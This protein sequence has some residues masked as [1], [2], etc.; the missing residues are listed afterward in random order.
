MTAAQLR[1][2]GIF[3][4]E[5][6]PDA[7]QQLQVALMRCF[8][9]RFDECPTQCASSCSALKGIRPG[10]CS[11]RQ[12]NTYSRRTTTSKKGNKHRLTMFGCPLNPKTWPRQLETSS[13]SLSS[14]GQS[15][16]SSL[17]SKTPLPLRLRLLGLPSRMRRTR[18]RGLELPPW[19]DSALL[20][21]PAQMTDQTWTVLVAFWTRRTCVEYT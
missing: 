20:R 5:L 7:V 8:L 11:T 1:L 15:F 17:S 2:L 19:R 14:P 21:H 9:E 12:W 6:A 10:S 18:W 3:P 4:L 16:R 13:S